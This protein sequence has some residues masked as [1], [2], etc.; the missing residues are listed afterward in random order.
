[1]E[2]VVEGK[3]KVEYQPEVIKIRLTF[4]YTEKT[5]DK[6][7]ETGTDSFENF[8]KNVLPKL[9]LK[10]EDL[11][12]N[13]FSIEHRIDEDYRTNKKIDMELCQVFRHIFWKDAF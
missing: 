2:I 11:K 4:D 6:A 12:T 7:L 8:V 3:G 13:K 10:K 5:Y 9:N 1:M